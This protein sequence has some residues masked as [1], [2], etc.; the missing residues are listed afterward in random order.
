MAALASDY[1]R[2]KRRSTS[3]FLY[4]NFTD[5]AP[6]V[7]AKLNAVTKVPVNEIK[8][9]LD[10]GGEV[11]LDENK[12]LAEQKVEN[13]QE[14]FMV[15]KKEGARA[16]RRGRAPAQAERPVLCAQA[17][18]SGKRSSCRRRVTLLWAANA[19]TVWCMRWRG[20]VWPGLLYRRSS[21]CSRY[22]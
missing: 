7:R 17:A 21:R 13:D 4:V 19:W 2:V 9:Y 15:Y 22:G 11:T 18:T 20:F 16:A 3:I 12:T 10:A 5:T 1:V 8:L 14:M 6:E